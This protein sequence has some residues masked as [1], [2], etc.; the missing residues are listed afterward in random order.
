MRRY[1]VAADQL[2]KGLEYCS[3]H[4][5]ELSLLYL[6]SFRAR[7]YLAQ[8]RWAQAADAADVVLRI[9]RTSISP[10][11]TALRV[12]GLVRA[13]RGDPGHRPL[14]DEAWELARPTGEVG[15]LGPVAAARAE[16]AW[17]ECDPD[18][19]ASATELA[20]ALALR[21]S[22]SLADELGV[23]RHRAGLGLREARS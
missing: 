10:R 21:C 11:I 16:A 5:L 19:V 4:G 12:L 14:L 3:D 15:R 8:G 18:G 7:L 6:L 23:W 9:P 2:A 20:L 1:D 22:S 13:R 17:L